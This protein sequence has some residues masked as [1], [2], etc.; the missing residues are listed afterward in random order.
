MTRSSL[1]LLGSHTERQVKASKDLAWPKYDPLAKTW[2]CPFFMAPNNTRVVRR[3]AALHAMWGEPYGEDFVYQEAMRVDQPLA[4]SK[5]MSVTIGL[6]AFSRLPTWSPTRRLMAL[7]LPKPGEG[8]SQVTMDK[9]WFRCDLIGIA[10]DGQLMRGHI[11]YAGDHRNRATTKFVCE[12]ALALSGDIEALPGGA[13]R[14]GV[15]TPA[16]GLGLGFAERLR[17]AGM[18]I[19]LSESERLVELA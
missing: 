16:T 18:M 3:S 14:G 6:A 2:I 10:S 5:A 11:S 12:S 7:V 1:D 19:E 13:E 8:P 15:L 17:R 9:G 4:K